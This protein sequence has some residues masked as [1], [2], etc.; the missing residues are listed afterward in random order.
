MNLKQKIIKFILENKEKEFT[1]RELSIILKTDYKNTY[2]AVQKISNSLKINKKGNASYISFK[3]KLTTLLYE[4]EQIRKENLVKKIKII[5]KDI[6][7]IEN[8]FFIVII[9]GSYAKGK[10]TKN[11]D[12]DLCLI[13]DNEKEIKEISNKLL[14][15]PKINIQIFNYT[16][17]ISMLKTKEF[18]VGHKI[19]KDG[20]I[21]KNIES[22]YE[23]IK[24]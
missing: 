6:I 24:H 16:E 15:H 21:L 18:N 12:I 19:R 7:K 10:Q 13:H 5:Y 20:I 11:S 22:Y 3:P 2:D 17:F 1:I 23:V 14:I 9:F 8:P 4:I